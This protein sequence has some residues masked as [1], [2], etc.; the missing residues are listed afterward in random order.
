MKKITVALIYGG[1]SG[2]HEVSLRSAASVYQALDPEKYQVVPIGITKEGQ[3]R[4]GTRL[5]A[6]EFQKILEAG[7]RV[8]LPAEPEQ[9]CF[10]QF[11]P[12]QKSVEQEIRIDV[13]FPVLHGPFGED[14]TIQGLLEM[15]NLPYVGAGV[16][17]SAA[18]MDKDVMK[19]L[20]LQAGLPTPAHIAFWDTQW[21]REPDEIRRRIEEQLGYPCFVKPANLGSSVGISKAKNGEQLRAALDLAATFDRKIIVEQ[22]INGREIECSVLGNEEPRASLPGEIIPS[23]EFYDYESKY[24]D[25]KS[26]LIIPAPLTP[27]QT[28]RVQELAVQTFLATECAGMA[29][30]DFFVEKTKG[31]VLVNE[32]NTIPGFTSISMY[33]KLWEASGI[34]YPQLIDRL[35]ELALERHARRQSKKT[36]CQ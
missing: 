5:L 10:L 15:A 12:G 6:G 27:E 17:G 4:A 20:L 30:V 34:S 24:L 13:A 1:K 19:R 11:S 29:R 22:F 9:N 14:G 36:S 26:E 35:I 23:R 31:E 28:R 21:S 2:E 25:E 8:V 33:P 32:I 3:W 18:G 16:L 7:E